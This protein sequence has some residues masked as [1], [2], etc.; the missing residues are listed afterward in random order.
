M[1]H[2]LSSQEKLKKRSLDLAYIA[3]CVAL[4]SVC[5]WIS[6]PAYVPFTLQ[7]FAVFFTLIILGGK[8]GTIAILS[9]LLLGLCGAPV[10]ANFNG[11]IAGFVNF[12]SGYLISFLFMGLFYWPFSIIFKEKIIAQIIGLTFGLIICYTLGTIFFIFLYTSRVKEIT[13]VSA[14]SMCVF[15]FIPFDILKMALAIIIANVLKKYMPNLKKKKKVII[16]D[17][18]ENNAD[19]VDIKKEEDNLDS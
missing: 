13:L 10:F 11:G 3:I 9:Y 19:N 1:K 5:S 4:I 15:P 7:T 18:N 6:I 14:L 17:I 12:S 16:N 2:K 8:R